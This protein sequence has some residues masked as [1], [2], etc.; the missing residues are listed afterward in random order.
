MASTIDSANRATGQI[1]VN[2]VVVI[3]AQTSGK[4]VVEL[5]SESTANVYTAS[6]HG[7]A[8]RQSAYVSAAAGP[9]TTAVFELLST[10]PMWPGPG[11]Y[12]LTTTAT[13]G[14]PA[15]S[16]VV[17]YQIYGTVQTYVD[18]TSAHVAV[19][20][21]ATGPAI[22]ATITVAVPGLALGVTHHGS[23]VASDWG[24][25]PGNGGTANGTFARAYDADSSNTIGVAAT[26]SVTT[27][28]T[29]ILTETA[30]ATYNRATQ[31]LVFFPDLVNTGSAPTL[32]Q[33]VPTDGA[34]GVEYYKPLVLRFNTSVQ[35][36]SSPG[37]ITIRKVSDSS[38]VYRY[39]ANASQVSYSGAVVRIAHP[40]LPG[41]T[42]LYVEIDATAIEEVGGADYAGISG[43]TT[44]DFATSSAISPTAIYVVGDA[45]S[46][47]NGWVDTNYKGWIRQFTDDING[48]RPGSVCDVFGGPGYTYGN[49][50]PDGYVWPD[51]GRA[52]LA[53]FQIDGTQ[54]STEVLKRKPDLFISACQSD[55][56]AAVNAAGSNIL[57]VADVQAFVDNEVIPTLRAIRAEVI[58][59]GAAWCVITDTPNDMAASPTAAEILIAEGKKYFS[60]RIIATFAANEV[61]DTYAVLTDGSSSGTLGYG[62][63]SATYASGNASHPNHAGHQALADA[64]RLTHVI[65]AR[66]G[67]KL[68]PW[69]GMPPT[70]KRLMYSPVL[71]YED[72]GAGLIT[73]LYNHGINDYQT[74]G[75]GQGYRHDA[76]PPA[77]ANSPRLTKING[78]PAMQIVGTNSEALQYADGTVGS[79][80]P[81]TSL[82]SD[83]LSHT[84]WIAYRVPAAATANNQLLSYGNNGLAD[85]FDLIRTN[86]SGG[87]TN[88]RRNAPTGSGDVIGPTAYVSDS[89][90]WLWR[91]YSGGTTDVGSLK[92]DQ[93][94]LATG[95]QDDLP[96]F[97]RLTIGANGRTTIT[98][99]TLT[100][101]VVAVAIVAGTR[102][103]IGSKA[104]ASMDAWFTWLTTSGVGG[105]SGSTARAGAETITPLALATATPTRASSGAPT[106]ALAPASA[107]AKSEERNGPLTFF[108]SPVGAGSGSRSLE[109]SGA[110]AGGIAPLLPGSRSQE[111][112]GALAVTVGAYAPGVGAGSRSLE[113]SGAVAA[114]LSAAGRGSASTSAGGA[115]APGVGTQLAG[116]QADSESGIVVIVK[117]T[118]VGNLVPV[119]GYTIKAG[120]EFWLQSLP[121]ISTHGERP[122]WTDFSS[123]LAAALDVCSTVTVDVVDELTDTVISGVV[124]PKGFAFTPAGVVTFWLQAGPN[125]GRAIVRVGVTGQNTNFADDIRFAVYVDL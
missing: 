40:G 76:R 60:T 68:A 22:S 95:T 111:H 83:P 91:E 101:E 14:T 50:A 110:A 37:Y 118:T 72:N 34:T 52:A 62:K 29:V 96:V 105:G 99:N 21:N 11:T 27:S 82:V 98:Y 92:G 59:S 53:N 45:S 64:A 10:D 75:G 54:N 26:R 89:V 13:L 121:S 33:T 78:R 43:A 120:E 44:W 23:S 74:A 58:A 88:A 6:L 71:G 36:Q 46:T 103:Q 30:I 94:T 39:A 100:L 108:V 81:V 19:S 1:G 17:A 69:T 107:G 113:R 12:T 3:S 86:G 4:L 119:R 35:A 123:G 15:D 5:N 28:G 79:T 77:G 115:I 65:H 112:S 41:S 90:N 109:R 57:T 67:P 122:F 80:T 48:V 24:A 18:S 87:I 55:V 85:H 16:T 93:G 51:A 38:V 49:L 20:D 102:T 61:I 114:T 125:P 9:S 63:L 116:S 124:T 8:L 84:E 70:L 117:S 104:V 97:N 2:L 42:S 106:A 32:T 47:G 56:G 73:A 66:V 7:V 25:T 31:I